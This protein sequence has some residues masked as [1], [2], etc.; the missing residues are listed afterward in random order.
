MKRIFATVAFLLVGLTQLAFA[1]MPGSP[2]HKSGSLGFH[3]VEAPLGVRWWFSGQKVGLDAGF[4]FSSEP[5]ESD[6]D[7]SVL[8]WAIGVGVPFVAHSWER[9]HLLL[10]PGLLYESQEVG[11]GV[12]PLFDTITQTTLHISGEFEAE[13]FLTDNF[14]V[15]AS[16]GIE[17][18]SFDPDLPNTDS[19]TTFQSLGRN[20]TN[21]GFHIYFLGGGE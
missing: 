4:G 15:S 14:S 10:R 5:A 16:H 9:V 1:D 19:Q 6:P 21:I 2:T 20:F 17:F 18:Q 12:G 8:G 7:E 3:D 11:S 13:A